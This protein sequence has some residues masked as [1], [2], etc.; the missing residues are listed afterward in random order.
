MMKKKK[1]QSII[2]IEIEFQEIYLQALKSNWPR[3]KFFLESDEHYEFNSVGLFRKN[4]DWSNED[5]WVLGNAN[6]NY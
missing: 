2:Q 5:L 1:T 4:S 3:A 6:N